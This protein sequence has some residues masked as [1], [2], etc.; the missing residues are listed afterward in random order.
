MTYFAYGM[1]QTYTRE[2]F[3]GYRF[4]HTMIACFD[5]NGKLKWDTFLRDDGRFVVPTE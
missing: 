3:D 4:T 5:E 1:P 2:V